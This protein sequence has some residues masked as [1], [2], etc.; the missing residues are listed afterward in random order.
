MSADRDQALR[1]LAVLVGTWRVSG[2]DGGEP[3]RV[4]YRWMEGGRFLI[5]EVDLGDDGDGTKGVEYIGFDTDTGTLRSHFFGQSGEI[6][7]YTYEVAGNRLTIWF[8]DRSSPARFE[9]TFNDD[10][11]VNTGRWV[12]PGGGYASTMVKV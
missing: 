1:S 7:E 6:L 3:G 8:G 2:W 9:G 5:Q 12:W 11:T 10:F 4:T